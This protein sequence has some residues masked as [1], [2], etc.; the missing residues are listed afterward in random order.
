M[1]EDEL[2]TIEGKLEVTIGMIGDY[3]RWFCMREMKS[4]AEQ[5]A[6]RVKMLEYVLDVCRKSVREENNV[7]I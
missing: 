7:R 1:T 5:L 3:A 2:R 6:Y 4:E